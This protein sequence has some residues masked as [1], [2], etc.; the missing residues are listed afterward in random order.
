MSN[1]KTMNSNQNPQPLT[2]GP[3]VSFGPD[4]DDFETPSTVTVGDRV[5]TWYPEQGGYLDAD[6]VNLYIEQADNDGTLT[7][8][9]YWEYSA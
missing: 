1:N 6:G 5:F 3:M 8:E 2:F 4:M 7:V 9:S